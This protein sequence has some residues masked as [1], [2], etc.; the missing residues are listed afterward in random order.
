MPI[1]GKL[2]RCPISLPPRAS[3][4]TSTYCNSWIFNRLDPDDPFESMAAA[5]TE[6]FIVRDETYKEQYIR[7]LFDLYRFDG[8]I[9]HDA[10]HAPTTPITAT[11]MPER[12]GRS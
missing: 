5:Y 12:L 9:F 7:N 8:I 4:V 2:S 10:R 6:L 1:W 11:A 3:V